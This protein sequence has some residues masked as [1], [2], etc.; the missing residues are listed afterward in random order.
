MALNGTQFQSAHLRSSSSVATKTVAPL[1]KPSSFASCPKNSVVILPPKT[2][3]YL[4]REAFRGH[5]GSSGVISRHLA[6]EDCRVRLVDTVISHQSSSVVIS[7]HQS[8]SVIISRHQSSSCRVRLV[9]NGL[10]ATAHVHRRVRRAKRCR[11]LARRTH[12][13]WVVPD[14]GGNQHAISL[15]R[16]MHE[17]R[18]VPERDL[19]QADCMLRERE[20]AVQTAIRGPSEAH[21][22]PNQRANSEGQSE[23]LQRAISGTRSRPRDETSL[24]LRTQSACTSRAR[25]PRATATSKKGNR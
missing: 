23:G 9:D 6:A 14:E 5:Q 17:C 8:S 16:R 7:R 18:V 4:M 10:V 19:L 20:S 2:P 25:S 13:C 15:S 3:A 22:R 1:T 21:Q 12:E 11:R 24:G